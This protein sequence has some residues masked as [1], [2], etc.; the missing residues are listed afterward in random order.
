MTYIKKI[1]IITKVEILAMDKIFLL[2]KTTINKK[3][4]DIGIGKV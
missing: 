2:T 3:R 1:Q 4:L